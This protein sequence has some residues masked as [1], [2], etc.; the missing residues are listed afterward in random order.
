MDGSKV[1]ITALVLIICA[2]ILQLLG[3]ASPYWISDENSLDPGSSYDPTYTGLWK[4][5]DCKDTDDFLLEHDMPK[6]QLRTSQAMSILG[7]LALM[8]ALVLTVTKLFFLKD[9]TPLLF[10]AISSVYIGAVSIIMS[11]GLFVDNVKSNDEKFKGFEFH[12]AFAFCILGMLAALVSGGFMLLELRR[13]VPDE[14]R[15]KLQEVEMK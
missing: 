10:V 15:E 2:T 13:K 7:F 1:L 4:K 3:L 14:M 5:C 8:L 11:V 9:R 12:F 6:R